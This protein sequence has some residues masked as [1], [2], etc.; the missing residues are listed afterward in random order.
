MFGH[1]WYLQNQ[2]SFPVLQKVFTNKKLLRINKALLRVIAISRFIKKYQARIKDN[3][4]NAG[5]V[6]LKNISK[7]NKDLPVSAILKY[8]QLPY[9]AYLRIKR[10]RKC[11]HSLLDLC[12]I[13]HPAQLLAKE[14][15]VIKSYCSDARW[16]R[17]PLSSVYHQIIRD[18]AATITIS[19][20][21]K[22]VGL[23]KLQRA[24]AH[25]R[26]KHHHTGIRAQ[27]PLQIIHADAT[28]QRTLDNAKN[29]IYLVQD[30]YS[31]AILT[32]QVA[33]SCKAQ[34]VFENLA[35]VRKQYL[36]PANINTCQ[37]IT[38]DG[39][40]NHG[41]V[42]TLT[43]CTEFPLIQHLVAQRN[44]EYS[45]S[46]IE[47]AN[48][49]LKYRF[50][51]HQSIPDFQA[52]QK[53]VCQAIEDYNNRPHA[54]LNGLTPLEV[55]NGTRYDKDYYRSQIIV[56]KANRIA[57]NKRATCCSFSF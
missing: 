17:W 40:E 44:I 52:L 29:Y 39:S 12:H 11:G 57:E 13:K 41:P 45:N 26:R 53:Y 19:T 55:L 33:Q 30:N 34:Y 2:A 4:G 5:A 56:A 28:I 51:Y 50:L 22:Y 27:A 14:V 49:Q 23:L 18:K 35:I 1:E 10:G 46:M 8:I 15:A 7:A 24:K 37:L 36:Q 6:V 47:A 42:K 32:H 31:R 21:Y 48:K 38:D 3:I 20:F 25:H 43:S 16:L 9:S 54:A